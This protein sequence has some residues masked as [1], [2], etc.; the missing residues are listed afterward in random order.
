MCRNRTLARA[1]EDLATNITISMMSQA[2]LTTTFSA[3]VATTRNRDL[4]AVCLGEGW[5][6]GR[7]ER[8]DG[9]GRRGKENDLRL[10]FGA[11]VDGE[12]RAVG[13]SKVGFGI[14][15]RV[16]TLRKGG[17]YV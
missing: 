11:L 12:G 17:R 4:D 8:G 3:I 1:I 6:L 14:A 7:L 9:K 16:V 5:G 15:E 2:Q 13:E 10:R